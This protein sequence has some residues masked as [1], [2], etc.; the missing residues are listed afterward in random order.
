MY[1]PSQR[2]VLYP[3]AQAHIRAKVNALSMGLMS[4]N[5]SLTIATA[6]AVKEGHVNGKMDAA[7][8]SAYKA[9]R[10][11]YNFINAVAAGIIVDEDPIGLLRSAGVFDQIENMEE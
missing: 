4:A 1:D 11:Y 8:K 5:T 10:V 6:I 9:Q 3:D 7:L 2:Q